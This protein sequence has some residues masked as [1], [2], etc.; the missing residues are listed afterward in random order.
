MP[1]F[2]EDGWAL[3]A[4]APML[5]YSTFMPNHSQIGPYNAIIYKGILAV[6]TDRLSPEEAAA[7]VVDVL[8]AELGDDVIILD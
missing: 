1:R 5:K 7:F 2:I 6:E 8:D 3:R 4:G